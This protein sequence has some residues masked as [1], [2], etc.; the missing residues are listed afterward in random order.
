MQAIES[1]IYQGQFGTFTITDEDRQSVIIYRT[2]LMI[3]AV[4]FGVGTIA[5][6]WQFSHT[7]SIDSTV[8]DLITFLFITFS[9]GL[10]IALAMI[11]IYMVVLHHALQSFW[12]IGSMSAIICSLYYHQPIGSIVYEQPL[13]ILG[14]GFTFAALT[15][16][17]FKEAF[18][19]N[20]FETKILTFLVPILLLGH[21]TKL[22]PQN[23][24]AT[25]LVIWAGLFLVF[26]IRKA[27]Q[28]IPPDLGDKSVFEYLKAQK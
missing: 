10:G 12:A 25:L 22:L 26:A 13:T 19:F 1:E 9:I 15:G 11:H 14:I 16:I 18:C 23:I 3:A 28:A 17:F 27:I 5:V 7:G 21:L 24:E 6:L 20:R 2:A 8:L 4:S